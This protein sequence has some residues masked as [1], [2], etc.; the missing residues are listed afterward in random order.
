V[1]VGEVW[2]CSGQ[3]NMGMTVNRCNNA[4]QEIA[5]AKYPNIRLFTVGRNPAPEPVDDVEGAWAACS[6][7][8]VADFS[9][10][11][12][13]FGRK[14]HEELGVAVGLVNTSW[15]GSLCEAWTSREALD[16]DA[17]FQPILKR[18][19]KF[20]PG[21]KNQ[22]AVL[23][24]GMIAPIVPLGIRGAIWYQGESN[25]S[26]AEQYTKLFPT[27]IADWRKRWGQGDF[28]VLF[29]QL[30]PFV[31]KNADPKCLAEL[32]EAQ[33][34][35]LAVANTGMAVTTDVG[36]LKDIHPKNKQEVGR[37]LAL[38]ALAKTYGKD[39]VYSGPLYKEMKIEGDKIR[40]S[41]DH[42]GGGLVAKDGPLKCFTIAGDD[43]QFVPAEAAID[44][45]SI[46]ASS[47]QV[48]KPV[49][50]RFAWQHDAEPNL[51]NQAGL[52][53]SP[54]RTDDLPRV[55]AGRQ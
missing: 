54:F 5:A 10:A 34:K 23:Y 24:N 11:A 46:V 17:D 2:L 31:Y 52:P 32:W 14:L 35:T 26:R 7:A 20:K 18:S 39:Q 51:F 13:F 1:L 19:A 29:V 55:T 40:L 27:M 4:D 33:A 6:P 30:A 42:L 49:A 28:P 48:K 36:D 9:A 21:E 3:S 44:G 12:Y 41:F 38:W 22:A 43:G 8:T 50:V 53:A 47:V 45:E 25:V 37:R 16:G 15:G